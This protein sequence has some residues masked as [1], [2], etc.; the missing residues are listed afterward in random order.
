MDLFA[1]ITIAII[2]FILIVPARFD[3]AIR[4]KDWV[5]SKR[6]QE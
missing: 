2:L 5:E 6:P 3:P 4:L 1:Y